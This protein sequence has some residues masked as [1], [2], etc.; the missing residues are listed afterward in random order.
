MR[1]N[2]CYKLSKIYSCYCDEKCFEFNDCC[3]L[4]LKD[5]ENYFQILI[6][7]KK[8]QITNKTKRLNI[9]NINKKNFNLTRFDINFS[10]Q[11]NFT[12]KFFEGLCCD[13]AI[14]PFDCFCDEKCEYY[15]DCCSD[16]NICKK[17]LIL[18]FKTIPNRMI[19]K[20]NKSNFLIK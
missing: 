14:E 12:K 11:L 10:L 8:H 19:L 18:N 20:E 3:D 5:C 1:Q 2:E 7:R 17:N 4:Y 13:E 6:E 16:F 9:T 15:L